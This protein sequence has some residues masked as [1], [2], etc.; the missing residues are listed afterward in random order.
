MRSAV[1]LNVAVEK[2]SATMINSSVDSGYFAELFFEGI[3]DH[4]TFMRRLE[5]A[6]IIVGDSRNSYITPEDGT[7]RVRIPFAS[8]DPNIVTEAVERIDAVAQ[9]SQ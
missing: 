6:G 4:N 3:T 7:G 9:A 8:L 2:S 5:G 1:A